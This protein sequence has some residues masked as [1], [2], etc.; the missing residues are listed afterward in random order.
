M[1]NYI[2]LGKVYQ[3]LKPGGEFIFDV[4]TPRMRKEESHSWQYYSGGDFLCE[5]SHICLDS[6][7]QY[8]DED[9]TELRQSI[10]ISNGLK[11]YNIWDHF[12]KKEKLLSEV[13]TAGFNTFEFYGDIAGAEYSDTGKTICGVFIK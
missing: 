5:R 4:F 9:H 8:D 13:Q 2:L 11:C 6:V 7:Y 12:F 10:I 1:F 3:A